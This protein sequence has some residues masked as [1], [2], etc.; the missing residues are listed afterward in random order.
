ML[1]DRSVS[2]FHSLCHSVDRITDER[3][4]GRR[5]NLARARGD[6]LEVIDL[7]WWSGSARGFHITFS[8]SSPLRNRRF[9]DICYNFSVFSVL[10]QST[11]DLYHTWRNNWRRRIFGWIRRTSGSR[12]IRKS[13]FESR[14]T[15]VSNFSVSGGLH[16]LLQT[17][18][19]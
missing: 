18:Y 19:L 17:E 5:L 4:N 15:F 7:W 6:P 13:E 3:G 16:S 10:I 8:F 12:L 1:Y 11:A 9:S 14:I 2:F